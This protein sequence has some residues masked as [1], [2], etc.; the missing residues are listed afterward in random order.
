M[1]CQRR[2]TEPRPGRA[3]SVTVTVRVHLNLNNF[4]LTQARVKPE[5]QTIA[6]K[7]D[8][9]TE[10]QLRVVHTRAHAIAFIVAKVYLVAK[11]S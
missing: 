7:T 9:E 8:D 2:A 6:T 4:T 1:L 5:R 3:V 11:V 10:R